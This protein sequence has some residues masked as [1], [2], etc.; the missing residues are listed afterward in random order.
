MNI[1]TDL[2]DLFLHLDE[3]LTVVTQT[4]GSLTY[5]FLFLVI[6]METGLV[7][8]PF[9]RVIHSCLPLARWRPYPEPG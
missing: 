3:H 2:L 7:I 4:Y 1:L 5:F 6:F 9:Y 8:T